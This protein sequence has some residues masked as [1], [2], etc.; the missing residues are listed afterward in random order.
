MGKITPE[1]FK[2]ISNSLFQKGL[3]HRDIDQLTLAAGGSLFESGS[4]RGLD[5]REIEQMIDNLRRNKSAHS[6]SDRQIDIVEEVFS[7]HL[8]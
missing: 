6:L 3:S 2:D 7:K 8:D 1:E 5:R 4:H